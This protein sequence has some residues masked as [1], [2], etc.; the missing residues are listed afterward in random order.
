VILMSGFA[1]DNQARK[2]L[3]HGAVAFCSKPFRLKEL[4]RL[5]SRALMENSTCAATE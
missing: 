3:E 4:R 2:L 1:A 5:L